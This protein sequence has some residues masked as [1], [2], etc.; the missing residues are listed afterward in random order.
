MIANSQYQIMYKKSP[1]SI[2]NY[3]NIIEQIMEQK[4]QFLN[5]MQYESEKDM[6]YQ[7]AKPNQKPNYKFN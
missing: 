2:N 7:I 6:K 1:T 5:S 4:N 3:N